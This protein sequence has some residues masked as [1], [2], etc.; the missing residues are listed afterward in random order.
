MNVPSKASGNWRW[1][2]SADMLTPELSGK[3]ASLIEVA[4][5]WPQPVAQ[6][7]NEEWAT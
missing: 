7:I 4:D 6:I 2:F 5:R 3:L 1:R